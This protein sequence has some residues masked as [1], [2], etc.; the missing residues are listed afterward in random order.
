MNILVTLDHNYLKQLKVMLY[1]LIT[2]D[3]QSN[4]TVYVMN[5]ALTAHDLQSVTK[6]I[7]TPRLKLVDLKVPTDF[8]SGAPITDRYPK[9]MYYRILAAQ[10]LPKDLDRILY[11]DPDLVVLKPLTELYE[12]SFGR[13]YFIAASHVKMMVAAINQIRLGADEMENYINSGV[14]M[15]NLE[16]LRKHQN[17]QEVYDY[18]RSNKAKLILPDQDVIYGLYSKK[19]KLVDPEV[20]NMTERLLTAGML[21]DDRAIKWVINNTAIVHYIGR[22]KPWKKNYVGQLGFLYHLFEHLLEIHFI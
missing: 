19:I 4:F 6:A 15:I 21:K 12:M 10:L 22:N 16:E 9:E 1:S 17:V 3:K 20:Y 18:I 8:F 5:E 14:M 2:T 7:G 11:L 13:H